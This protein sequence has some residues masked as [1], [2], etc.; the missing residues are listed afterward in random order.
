MTTETTT[1]ATRICGAKISAR[2]KSRTVVTVVN[3]T[4]GG[5]RISAAGDLVNV[6]S[7]TMTN[8]ATPTMD[9]ANV[10][11]MTCDVVLF[12]RI[13]E[14]CRPKT[15]EIATINILG[16]ILGSSPVPI[17]SGAFAP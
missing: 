17:Q 15:G 7:T 10:F 16:N 3:S 5:D 9:V 2:T 14:I 11:A 13:V 8:H 6:P 4:L 1:H 12:T